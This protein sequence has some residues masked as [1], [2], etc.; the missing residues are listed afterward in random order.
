MDNADLRPLDERSDRAI[1]DS[2]D[3]R[4][5]GHSDLQLDLSYQVSPRLQTVGSLKYD[6]LWRDDR[7]GRS[8]RLG[9]R[10]EH[11]CNAFRLSSAS[12]GT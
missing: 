4:F 3:R 5:F 7:I 9:R 6:V 1:I 2:D 12:R 8:E 10:H 11:L